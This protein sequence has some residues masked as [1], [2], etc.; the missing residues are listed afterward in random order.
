MMKFSK[1]Q[2]Q[3]LIHN[4][5]DTCAALCCR[6]IILPLDKPEE[7]DDFDTIKFY[8]LHENIEVYIDTEDAWNI[9][10]IT[11]CKNLTDESTCRDYENRPDMC[12]HYDNSCCSLD[13]YLHKP[14]DVKFLFRTVEDLE[15]YK[16]LSMNNSVFNDTVIPKLF[17]ETNE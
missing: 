5:C 7:D 15:S 4:R 12:R 11:K 2:K 8:I 3:Y 13:I 16:K 6:Y 1:E 14:T 10:V 17:G 9:L